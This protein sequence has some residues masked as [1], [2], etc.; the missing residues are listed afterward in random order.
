MI[1]KKIKSKPGGNYITLK[2]DMKNYASRLQGDIRM[3]GSFQLWQIRA[4]ER[5]LGLGDTIRSVMG[6]RK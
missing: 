6:K 5:I 1:R 4:I 2:I 3:S